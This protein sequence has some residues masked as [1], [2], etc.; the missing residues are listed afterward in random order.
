MALPVKT[1][2]DYVVNSVN[3]CEPI[4]IGK[5]AS[6]AS[7]DSNRWSIMKFNRSPITSAQV[8]SSAEWPVNS[9][10]FTGQQFFLLPTYLEVAKLLFDSQICKMLIYIEHWVMTSLICEH[11]T[12]QYW[13]EQSSCKYITHY[14][15]SFCIHRTYGMKY[16]FLCE[17]KH[18]QLVV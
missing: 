5:I 6:N 9:A 11:V 3:M 17:Y 1:S 8:L 13:E 16:S 14:N 7:T 15:Y 2:P 18:Y 4:I 10:L 12:S